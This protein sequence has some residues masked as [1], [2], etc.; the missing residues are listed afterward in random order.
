MHTEA[1]EEWACLPSS[2]AGGK[3]VFTTSEVIF[4]IPSSGGESETS[5]NGYTYH[6]TWAQWGTQRGT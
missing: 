1:Q 5:E 4:N 2:T 6:Q 3:D